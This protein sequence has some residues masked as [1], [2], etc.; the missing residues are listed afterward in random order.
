LPGGGR[1][2][3][4]LPFNLSQNQKAGARGTPPGTDMIYNAL[5]GGSA[6][7]QPEFYIAKAVHQRG[8]YPVLRLAIAAWWSRPRLP[9]DLPA[10]LRADMGLPPDTRPVFWPEPSDN[11]QVPLIAW[12]PGM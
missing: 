11:P 9:A 12:R 8:L 10:R 2:S 4:R 6:A 1:S 3:L 7:L 5:N